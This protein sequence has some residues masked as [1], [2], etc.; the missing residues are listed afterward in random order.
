MIPEWR[1]FHPSIVNW[2]KFLDACGNLGLAGIWKL[3]K[4]YLKGW[5]T[6][7][8]SQIIH[9]N[10]PMLADPS[11]KYVPYRAVPFPSGYARQWPNKRATSAPHWLSTDLRDVFQ[12]FL[13]NPMS[14]TTKLELFKVLLQIGFKE[15]EV[16]YPSASDLE[17]QFV[18]CLIENNEVPDGITLQIITPA[19]PDLIKKSIAS[20]AGAKH[21][22]IHLYNA[23][24]PVFREVVFRNTKEQTIELTLNAV[25]LVKE[26]TEAETAR[27]GT[28]FTLNYCL[29]TF[30][31]TEPEFAVE[32]G[33]RVL[34]AWGKATPNDKVIFNLV[35]TVECAPSNHYADQ[36]DD[37]VLLS[38]HP[39]NDRGTAVG[40]TELGLL[41]GGD[42]VE[43]CLLGNGERTGNVD[44]ITLALNLY[45]QGVAPN[46]DFSNLSE[47]VGAACRVNE[48]AVPTRYPYAGSLVFSAFAGTHQDA[49]TKGLVAQEKRWLSVD[50]SGEGIK[51][52]AI[53][54]VPVDPKDLGNGYD[55]LIRVS[56]Q[57]GKAG[58]AHV[59]K[60][61]LKL[62]MPRRMQVSFYGVV[63][64]LAEKSGKEMT[65]SMITDTFKK[66]YIIGAKPLG[67]LHLESYR[68]FPSTPD[69]S[70][71]PM[72]DYSDE[73]MTFAGE[74]TTATP[75]RFE[76][77]LSV[78]GAVCSI[79]VDGAIPV[80]AI[81]DALRSSLG[82]EFVAG[83]FAAHP[84][85]TNA[86]SYVEMHLP[87]DAPSNS[88]VSSVWG[89]GIS[90]DVATSKCRA[91]ISAVNTLIGSR[92]LPPA[93][94]VYQRP[95]ILTL[96]SAGS[97]FK[98]GKLRA[99]HTPVTPKENE[100]RMLEASS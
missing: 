6:P 19:R 63:Q 96:G 84:V 88:G 17:Y 27:S 36:V 33:N 45:S 59:I 34:E 43:G 55:D 54:Y 1:V 58:T 32:L 37:S 2:C 16:A 13:M 28:K 100:A 26:L 76:G 60:Q 75:L 11:T 90:S 72:S 52:W 79:R 31:Q 91:V 4:R 66:P 61:S 24:S 5:K 3:S 81:L 62:E 18:R 21:A 73:M 41:A 93:K 94:R 97:W 22:I 74:P 23:V 9:L 30:S 25:R 68:L 38:L 92:E 77:Q 98:V 42:C 29:E 65:V 83:E 20:L 53:P 15:I 49:I 71:S 78:D 64:T 85:D 47:I 80:L 8:N 51:S 12:I 56:S 82:I 40:A 57:S 87:A 86:C 50:R 39:H 46:L 89:V 99:G 7:S 67:R 14:N 95:P 48:M 44:L 69:A 10:M 35:A 70:S